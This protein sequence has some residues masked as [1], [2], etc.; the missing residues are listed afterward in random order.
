MKNEKFVREPR[1]VVARLDP[2]QW[3]RA[4]RIRQMYGFKSIYEMNQ[5]L[6]ACFLRAVDPDNEAEQGIVS[7]EIENVFGEMT[8]IRLPFKDGK[9][10]GR[11]PKRVINELLGQLSLYSE[12]DKQSFG[13]QRTR[14]P[15]RIA[16]VTD[17]GD[18]VHSEVADTFEALSRAEKHFEYVKPK[19]AMNNASLNDHNHNE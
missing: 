1:K 15:T 3:E 2:I 17:V 9:P 16:S 5:C 18:I 14:E 6:W 19:R 8:K 12:F 10:G 11:M 4:E 7:V 13:S